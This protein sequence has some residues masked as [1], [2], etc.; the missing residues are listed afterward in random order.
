MNKQ[1]LK[2]NKEQYKLVAADNRA[3]RKAIAKMIKTD[4]AYYNT[5]KKIPSAAFMFFCG[6]LLGSAVPLVSFVAYV[7]YIQY[8]A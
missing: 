5:R 3:R 2:R 1:I 4:A 7:L 8:F 6:A